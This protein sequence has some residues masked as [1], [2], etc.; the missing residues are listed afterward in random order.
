MADEDNRPPCK[1]G[2][3]C[4]RLN[5]DHKE[6]YSHPSKTESAEQ[7]EANDIDRKRSPSPSKHV[8]VNKS[9]PAKRRKTVSSD[10]ND[11]DADIDEIASLD[12][13]DQ[14]Q[15][16]STSNCDGIDDDATNEQMHASPAKSDE[17]IT[18]TITAIAES[19][20]RCSEYINEA[21]DKGPHAQRVEYQKLLD[22][23]AQF[24]HSKLLVK[25]PNDFFEFWSFCVANAKADSKPENLFS[26]FGLR[27][28][29]PFDVLAKKFHNIEPF[30]PGDYLRHWRFFYDPPEFQVSFAT[31][32]FK[33]QNF[34]QYRYFN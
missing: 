32:F 34:N 22:T 21:F 17:N 7:N 30:E 10:E 4:Y 20:I 13:N 15:I 16:E 18:S 29:G 1:Y 28:V 25:M 11:S 3:N 23:P 27:L 26:K 9:P 8:D 33:K 24:I 2:K 12:V 31:F 5:E 19:S 6:R 14:A